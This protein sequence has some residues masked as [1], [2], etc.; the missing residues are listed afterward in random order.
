MQSHNESC[1]QEM[2]RLFGDKEWIVTDHEHFKQATKTAKAVI[3]TGET[4]PFANV[5]LHSGVIF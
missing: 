2:H 3:R 4:T 1:W 5:I